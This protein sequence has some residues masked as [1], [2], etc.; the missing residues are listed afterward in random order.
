MVFVLYSGDAVDSPNCHYGMATLTS[1]LLTTRDVMAACL[2]LP[3][4]L[5]CP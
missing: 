2:G 4:P 1:V 3:T 5:L